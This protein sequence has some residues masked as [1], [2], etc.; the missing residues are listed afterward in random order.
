VASTGSWTAFQSKTLGQIR[1]SAGRNTIAVRV[2]EMPRGAVMNL[3]QVRL[4]PAG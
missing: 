4:V 2:K 3:R 1:L